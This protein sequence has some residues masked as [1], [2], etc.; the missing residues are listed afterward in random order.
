MPS[1]RDYYEVLGVPS[2]V[3]SEEIKKVFRRLALEYHPDRNNQ[4]DAEG[5]FKEIN[6]AYQ[7]LSSP[8][9]RT[10]Y[11]R[12]GH[13]GVTTNGAGSRGFEGVDPFGGFGDIFDAFFGGFGT[14]TS[15][16]PQRGRDLE[17]G[18]TI[19]FEEAVLGV[20][21]EVQVTR[22]EVCQRCKGS[23]SEPDTSVERCTTCQGSGQV[24]RSQQSLFG[25]FVQVVPCS[26]CHGQGQIIPHPCGQCKG[27]G[28][29]RF[30]RRLTVSIPA[31]VESG[32]QIRL[33]SEGDAGSRA[34]PPGDLYLTLHVE[35]HKAFK[36]EGTHLLFEFPVN[37][38]QAAL[39]A[40]V[41]VPTIQGK[42]SI[43]IPAGSQSGTVIRIRGEGVPYLRR[44][45]K[46]DLLVIL[47]IVTPRRLDAE[48]RRLFELLAKRLET[49]DGGLEDKGWVDRVKD[50]LGGDSA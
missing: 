19:S 17:V 23:A 35:E 10:A 40:T 31:G 21:K 47:R 45:G 50:A 20:Q 39:G 16:G 15:N 3:S 1:K 43:D 29:E 32:S 37:F 12:F 49:S 9:K 14:R 44:R 6:E 11:D 27:R 28:Y 5:R 4:P 24:R 48:E 22:T 7:V 38:A 2:N 26:T 46:G 33:S 42:T 8:E 41:D 18:L 36:R 25:S 30:S 34:G 13:A